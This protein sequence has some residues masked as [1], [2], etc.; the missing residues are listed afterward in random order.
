[1]AATAAAAANATNLH[2]NPATSIECA[3]TKVPET[4]SFNKGVIL[5]QIPGRGKGLVVRTAAEGAE[6][7]NEPLP[8]GTVLFTERA[9]AFQRSDKIDL[10]GLVC[11]ACGA[12]LL[13]PRQALRHLIERAGF[14]HAER[15][16]PSSS[17]D[18]GHYSCVG[19]RMRWC[20]DACYSQSQ[21]DGHGHICKAFAPGGC[22][23]QFLDSYPAERTC[24]SRAHFGCAARIIANVAQT[25]LGSHTL[26]EGEYAFDSV[27]LKRTMDDLMGS[28]YQANVTSS[29]HAVRT[30][31]VQPM[32]ENAIFVEHLRPGY[33]MA[34]LDACRSVML[35]VFEPLGKVFAD[36][37]L[38]ID[39]FDKLCGIFSTNNFAVEF[40]SPLQ[41]L[42]VA[43]PESVVEIV[44]KY[45]GNLPAVRGTAC[46]RHFAT[47]NH[48]CE[49]NTIARMS[50]TS[51]TASA[52]TFLPGGLS[53]S[54]SLSCD[55][56]QGQEIFNCYLATPK[57][58]S[59]EEREQDLC[60]YLF[61]CKCSRCVK[62]RLERGDSSSESD[63]Y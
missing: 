55:V 24:P 26:K 29:L 53:I 2:S 28:F 5:K 15:N 50:S 11:D 14:E 27:D 8:R 43:N 16:Y 37:L 62:E 23:C 35:T 19:C 46:F 44:S 7:N 56:P 63:D 47:L 6:C 33:R 59:L 40:A 58:D 1:M 31:S 57:T 22:L 18:C 3:A 25:C 41:T 12:W 42:Q 20:S 36:T 61:V 30:S 54:V 10:D 52:R 49:K 38:N 48:S 32:E 9:I 60:Q 17:R 34:Y 21:R 13:S 39:A 4:F 51:S 45:G